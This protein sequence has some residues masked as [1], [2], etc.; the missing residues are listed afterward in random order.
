MTRNNVLVFTGPASPFVAHRM[1]ARP[2][3]VIPIRAH[4][5]SRKGSGTYVLFAIATAFV[6]TGAIVL[7]LAALRLH[8]G[9]AAEYVPVWPW[10]IW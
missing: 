4:R 10:P 9:W 8:R 3:D 5:W 1:R 7:G 6:W 2:A